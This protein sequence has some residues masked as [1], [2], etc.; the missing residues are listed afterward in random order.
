MCLVMELHE[1][2]FDL[3]ESD[4]EGLRPASIVGTSIVTAVP[5]NT[6]F[7]PARRNFT[8]P[9]RVAQTPSTMYPLSTSARLSQRSGRARGTR[10]LASRFSKR[11]V[12]IISG[13]FVRPSYRSKV[14]S[15][16]GKRSEALSSCFI[17]ARPRLCNYK[18]RR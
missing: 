8:P 3:A 6:R 15:A 13:G 18:T 5:F 10:N 11:H 17:L 12:A 14:L 2:I 4:Y 7:L 16:L 9:R 1:T